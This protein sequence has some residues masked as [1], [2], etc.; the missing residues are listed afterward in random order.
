MPIFI[1]PGIFPFSR[2]FFFTIHYNFQN[3][4]SF[5]DKLYN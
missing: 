4:S 3:I 1:K 2:D 5:F